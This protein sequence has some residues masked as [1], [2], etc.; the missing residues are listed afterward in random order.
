MSTFKLFL[1]SG[2]YEFRTSAGAKTSGQCNGDNNGAKSTDWRKKLLRR[3]NE[4]VHIRKH[5]WDEVK[6]N[7]DSFDDYLETIIGLRQEAQALSVS[8][9]T[10]R[11][12]SKHYP[13]FVVC[14]KF[15]IL[16]ESIF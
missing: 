11:H 12:A 3:K 5:F 15:P 1:R 10:H 9:S 16:A 7:M 2:C 8:Q 13:R 14:R 4:V 6:V